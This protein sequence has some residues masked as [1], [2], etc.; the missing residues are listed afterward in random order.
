MQDHQSLRAT[1]MISASRI[2]TYTNIHGQ[3]DRLTDRQLFTVST[4]RTKN[5]ISLCEIIDSGAV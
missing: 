5:A 4:I 3:T 2:N 1:I